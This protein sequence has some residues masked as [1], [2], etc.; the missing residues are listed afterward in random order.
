MNYYKVVTPDM[1]SLGLRKN[2]NILTFRKNEWIKESSPK[3]GKQD[4]GGIW[5]ANGKGHANTLKKYMISKGV[6]ARVFGVEIGNIL[7]SNS[8]RTKTDKVRL[9]TEVS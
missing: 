4:T 2:P 8:Y 3:E 6:I 1:K 5:V 7:Y 9:L